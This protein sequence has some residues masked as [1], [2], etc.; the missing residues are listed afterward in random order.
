[1][2]DTLSMQNRNGGNGY[3]VDKF[4]VATGEKLACTEGS[5]WMEE[6]AS[7]D[8]VVKKACWVASKVS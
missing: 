1:M 3:K 4:R 6:A 8:V 2:T 5:R 7:E